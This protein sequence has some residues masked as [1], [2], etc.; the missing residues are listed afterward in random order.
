MPNCN[1]EDETNS[2]SL[3]FV[4]LATLAFYYFLVL[5]VSVLYHPVHVTYGQSVCYQSSRV[6]HVAALLAAQTVNHSMKSSVSQQQP[7]FR[8]HSTVRSVCQLF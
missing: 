2:N 4:L 6:G 7:A 3:I 8:A 5:V 1:Y